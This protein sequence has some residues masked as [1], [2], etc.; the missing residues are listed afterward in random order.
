MVILNTVLRVALMHIC[1]V[2][3]S[4]EF[5]VQWWT[6][7]FI[8][9]VLFSHILYLFDP[10]ETLHVLD[11]S[12]VHH[13][14]YFTVCTVKYSWWWTEELSETF[15][16]SLQNKIEKLVHLVGFILRKFY[17]L[18]KVKQCADSSWVHWYQSL[19]FCCCF[20]YLAQL[21]HSL[22]TVSYWEYLTCSSGS[23]VVAVNALDVFN[24]RA[25]FMIIVTRLR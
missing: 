24:S 17:I 14:E 6:V 10:H 8:D 23:P 16:V 1:A 13:R 12:C 7:S 25:E 20:W 3:L 22:D 21:N 5:Q 11:S 2:K 18:H 4:F 9:Q 19:N 15:R